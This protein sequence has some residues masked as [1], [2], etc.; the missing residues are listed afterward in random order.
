LEHSVHV[1]RYKC[2]TG[3]KIHKLERITNASIT[4]MLGSLCFYNGKIL[5]STNDTTVNKTLSNKVLFM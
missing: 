2:I 1:Y 5:C 4:L 3:V